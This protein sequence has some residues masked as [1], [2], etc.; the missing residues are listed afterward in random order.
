MLN[1]GKCEYSNLTEYHDQIKKYDAHLVFLKLGETIVGS[2][3]LVDIT[4]HMD[5][6][7]FLWTTTIVANELQGRGVS[8]LFNME[9]MNWIANYFAGDDF[10][11][12][13]DAK[14]NTPNYKAYTDTGVTT[15]IVGY[16]F[17]S[18]SL[19][20]E[21]PGPGVVKC[22]G[23]DINTMNDDEQ[24]KLYCAWHLGALYAE[25]QP[26]K[27]VPEEIVKFL[28]IIKEKRP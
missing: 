1:H 18:Y 27:M 14:V 22:C 19:S 6:N 9:T 10:M 4:V 5:V 15:T 16:T 28:E 21:I 25:L 13:L 26:L 7:A 8:T 2:R 12:Y 24:Q 3:L 20:N 17:K 11:V 23:Y